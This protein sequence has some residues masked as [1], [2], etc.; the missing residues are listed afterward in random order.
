MQATEK[1]YKNLLNSLKKDDWDF[2]GSNTWRTND[3]QYKLHLGFIWIDSW[4][5]VKST[6]VRLPYT[7]SFTDEQQKVL[8]EVI[9][10]KYKENINKFMDEAFK[11]D[12][13]G[14]S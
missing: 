8:S 6:E 5:N 10:K 12:Q 14:N 7:I 3:N 4:P 13:T 2:T 1:F 9:D 11:N